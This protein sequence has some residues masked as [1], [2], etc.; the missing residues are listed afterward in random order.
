MHG[1][2]GGGIHSRIL[3][4]IDEKATSHLHSASHFLATHTLGNNQQT[5][6]RFAP[7]EEALHLSRGS[8]KVAHKLLPPSLVEI[9]RGLSEVRACNLTN[10]ILA[11]YCSMLVLRGAILV[12]AS[13]SSVSSVS[14]ADEVSLWRRRPRC[15]WLSSSG[16]HVRPDHGA[17]HKMF[18][19]ASVQIRIGR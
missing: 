4:W 2:R 5:L 17:A 19:A 9:E 13:L 3:L 11:L 7:K 18:Y 8:V 6:S 10:H 1:F 14:L 15:G 16:R 12:A